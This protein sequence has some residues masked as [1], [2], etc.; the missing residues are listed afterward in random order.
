LI[1]EFGEEFQWDPEKESSAEK[2]KRTAEAEELRDESP[3]Q[4]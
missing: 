2:T 4:I 3:I 1:S